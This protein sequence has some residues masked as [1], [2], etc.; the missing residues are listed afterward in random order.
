M[1]AARAEVAP[2]F[3]PSGRNSR[4]GGSALGYD[5][6]CAQTAAF[7]TYVIDWTSC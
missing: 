3:L 1:G 4:L 5:V 2:A 6:D 7:S